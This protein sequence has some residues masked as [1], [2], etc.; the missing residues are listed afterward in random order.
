ML[1]RA[2]PGRA[3][4]FE[5]VVPSGGRALPGASPI[6]VDLAAGM[7]VVRRLALH[8]LSFE[9]LF[10]LFLFAGRFK[11]DPR[12]SW[13]PVDITLLFFLASFAVGVTVIWREQI[14]LPGLRLVMMFMAFLLWATASYAWTPGPL[15]GFSKLSELL[16]L[17]LWSLMGGALVIANRR[18]RLVR[19]LALL[20]LFATLIAVDWISF[21][22]IGNFTE[23]GFI[24]S[25]DYL[26][27][28]TVIGAGAIVAFTVLIY[29]PP[30]TLRWILAG[31]L[32]G[33]L[34]LTLFVI[35]GRSP[36][37]ALALAMLMPMAVHV[38]LA[39]G[40]LL[41]HRSQIL[42]LLVI[43]GGVAGVVWAIAS[44]EMTWTLMRFGFLFSQGAEDSSTTH[45]L[46]YFAFAL[47]GWAQAPLM[48][49]GIGS[50]GIMYLGFDFRTFPHNIFL[51]ALF[52]TGIL[53]LALLAA[54]FVLALRRL[55]LDRLRHEPVLLCVLMLFS[56]SFLFAMMSGALNEVRFLWTTLGLLLV[57]PLALV[58]PD[59]ITNR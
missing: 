7:R 29:A 16:S 46:S 21:Y 50:F 37:V 23:L 8:L 58:L 48:G 31:L 28:G 20:T 26:G 45:R 2:R 52:E 5:D 49:H 18:I 6:A 11:A 9:T 59:R 15:Y 10:V 4:H 43:L 44:G 56:A 19:F 24:K 53:G 30:L 38:R 12:F 3:T 35:G 34:T 27:A 39:E 33:L 14:Y 13:V 55:G 42:V 36:I 51:E 47:K 32:F 54:C 17:N 41:L 57:R 25:G 22:G 40:R 1:V